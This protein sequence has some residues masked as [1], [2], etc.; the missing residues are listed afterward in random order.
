MNRFS[1]FN[2]KLSDDPGF[3]FKPKVGRL[4]I[5]SVYDL[6]LSSRSLTASYQSWLARWIEASA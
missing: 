3:P 6:K 5:L 2:S 1:Y 4:L